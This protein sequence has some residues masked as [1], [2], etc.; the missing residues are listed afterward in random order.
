MVDVNNNPRQRIEQNL[1]QINQ[2]VAEIENRANLSGNRPNQPNETQPRPQTDGD[3]NNSTN[4][5][6]EG[7]NTGDNGAGNDN[8][9]PNTGNE[10]DQPE[11]QAEDN[12]QQQTPPRPIVYD[13]VSRAYDDV[14][15]GEFDTKAPRDEEK[16]V[17]AK[18][19]GS[20][21]PPKR[22]RG[23]SK[24]KSG[25]DNIME[26]FWNDY[27]MAFYLTAVDMVVDTTLDFA[28]WVLFMPYR[29]SQNI[30]EKEKDKKA[31]NIYMIGDD[32]Y[33]E[34][35]NN[36][37]Q[38]KEKLIE[39]N[40]NLD[41]EYNGIRP[42]WTLWGQMPP[43]YPKLQQIYAKAKQNPQSEEAKFIEK[44][45]FGVSADVVKGR[46][47]KEEKL[48]TLAVRLATIE[49]VV[50]QAKNTISP[51]FS[52]NL[53]KLESEIK[54]DDGNN[55]DT[56]RAKITAR[57]NILKTEAQENANESVNLKLQEM[58][59]LIADQNNGK[60]LKKEALNKLAEI[61]K[62]SRGL[63]GNEELIKG[64]ILKKSQIK[65]K[66]LMEN[67]DKIHEIYPNDP[68]RVK[69]TIK[70]YL[71]SVNETGKEAKK[72]TDKVI[73]AGKI[74]QKMNMKNARTAVE[75]ID[76]AIDDYM[77]ENQA[78]GSRA[79]AQQKDE[80]VLTKDKFIKA[81]RDYNLGR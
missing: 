16:T 37:A 40:E 72:A 53:S 43:F 60:K 54:K 63:A 7:N 75:K 13:G 2:N 55:A 4:V 33:K 32:F 28:E 1:Q 36:L 70:E 66:K 78:I 74:G 15:S 44:Y 68:D 57:L 21:T 51:A 45:G 31:K 73:N 59:S 3:E 6:P 17:K 5:A 71:T 80:F 46:F 26:V 49:E 14:I 29:S 18:G 39:L 52:E 25:G 11:P 22:E 30:V 65:Y 77:L 67:I 61:Q 38:E 10:P 62:E 47:A 23:G 81:I 76:S 8:N 34:R 56:L 12:T 24:G 20:I 19:K 64:H 27:I 41:K 9:T 69:E 79:E 58:E 48:F 50:N 35:M 42:Q